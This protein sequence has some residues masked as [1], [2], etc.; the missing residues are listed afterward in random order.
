MQLDIAN[1]RF[2]E[3]RTERAFV[4][5]GRL[6]ADKRRPRPRD[7][8]RKG[9]RG[10]GDASDMPRPREANVDPGL[11]NIHPDKN[12]AAIALHRAPGQSEN[13]SLGRTPDCIRASKAQ[14]TVRVSDRDAGGSEMATVFE[15][16][17]RSERPP[18]SPSS[19]KDGTLTMQST[20]RQR[21]SRVCLR[22]WYII[23]ILVVPASV[24]VDGRVKPGYDE[25]Q[26]NRRREEIN[27][28]IS[29]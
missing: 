26:K 9:L 14:T 25:R 11:R 12:F 27:K 6:H 15:D 10:V 4:T 13:K 21:Y 17:S 3:R 16:Q 29:I 20:H 5:S 7:P 8:R 22:T 2:R 18:A 1:A 23:N 24:H 28:L 19:T